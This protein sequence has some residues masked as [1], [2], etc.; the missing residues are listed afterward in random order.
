[1][2]LGSVLREMLF[3]FEKCLGCL[4]EVVQP[5]PHTPGTTHTPALQQRVR[6]QHV[7]ISLRYVRKF[8]N[9]SSFPNG[10]TS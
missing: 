8:N 3:G 4:G 10:P 7:H 6:F 2:V 1:M 5:A 9:E